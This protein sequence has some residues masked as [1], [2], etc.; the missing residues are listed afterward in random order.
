M[1]SSY[2][3]HEDVPPGSR[4]AHDIERVFPRD[5]ID[6]CVRKKPTSSPAS[7]TPRPPHAAALPAGGVRGLPGYL[8]DVLPDHHPAKQWRIAWIGFDIALVGALLATALAAWLKRQVV[9]LA[10]V[11]TATLLFCDAWFDIALDWGTSD[12]A[13][14]MLSGILCEIPLSIYLMRSA[15][16]LIRVTV[17]SALALSGHT[18]PVPP[19]HKMSIMGINELLYPFDRS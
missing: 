19:F 5:T 4:S 3:R 11:C 6:S 15:L 18:G 16:R 12:Q 7:R 8:A 9:I 10:A 2:R 13:A 1:P 14:S 17:R